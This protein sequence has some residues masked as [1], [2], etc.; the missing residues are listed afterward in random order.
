M[1]YNSYDKIITFC[2]TLN[3]KKIQRTLHED[4]KKNIYKELLQYKR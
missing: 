4:Y 1:T 2:Y 3:N